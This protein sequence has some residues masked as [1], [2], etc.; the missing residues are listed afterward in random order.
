LVIN[1]LYEADEVFFTGTAAEVT[2]VREIDDRAIGK[3]SRGPVTEKLQT[4]YFDLVHGR[5]EIYPEWL[6]L[7]DQTNNKIAGANNA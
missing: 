6:N 2:P 3:G 4:M 5:L 7:V 1:D